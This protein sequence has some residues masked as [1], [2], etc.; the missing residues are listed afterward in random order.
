MLR[1]DICTTATVSGVHQL[2]HYACEGGGMG[3]V[4]DLSE[5]EGEV[6]HQV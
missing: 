3:S 2:N 1:K 5:G 6:C 4:A